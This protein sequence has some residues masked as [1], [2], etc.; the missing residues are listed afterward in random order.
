MSDVGRRGSRA[1]RNSE[2]AAR[3][4]LFGAGPRANALFLN[5]EPIA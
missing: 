3:A 4:V 2:Q 1:P 5:G